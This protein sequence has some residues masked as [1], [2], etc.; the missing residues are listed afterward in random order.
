MKNR[1]LKFELF[2][3]GTPEQKPEKQVEVA[4]GMPKN[5]KEKAFDQVKRAKLAIIDKTEPDY[6]KVR[7]TNEAASAEAVKAAADK[8]AAL[9]QQKAAAEQQI[10]TAQTEL[11]KAQAEMASVGTTTTIAPTTTPP[12]AANAVATTAS[13]VPAAGATAAPAAATA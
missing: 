8:L 1:I 11:T 2:K 5:P 6:S 9:Q 12:P 7:K 13:T 4:G 3:K 10:I